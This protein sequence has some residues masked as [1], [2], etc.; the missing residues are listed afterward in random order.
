MNR[1][2]R[3][4]TTKDTKKKYLPQRRKGAKLKKFLSNGQRLAASVI[5]AKACPELCRRAGIQERRGRAAFSRIV[6]LRVLRGDLVF[7]AVLFL[8]PSAVLADEP[9]RA[10]T[11]FS[12]TQAPL[13]AAKEGRYFEKYGIKNLEVIQFSGG[14]PVT[15]ALIGGD[16]QIS[17]TGGAA[18][19]NARLKGADTVII[20]RTVG[21]FPY[22]LYVT[23]DIRDAADLKGKKLAV[24]TVG[25]SGYVAMQYALRKLGIDPDRDVAMLQ[26]G[27][28]GT[29]LASLASGTVQGTLLLPPFTLR[30]RDL[31]LKPLY[32]LVGS[33]IQYPINQITTRQ[34]FIKSQREIVKNF[35]RGFVAGLARFRTDRE[36]G[37]RVLGKNLHETDAKILQETYD[38]WL[39]VFPRVP[40]PG[41]EDATV[42]L[43]FMQVKDQRDWREFVDTSLMDE[44]EREGFTASVY[45]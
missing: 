23:K 4:F 36:F 29:R 1:D 42:F 35:L 39:K 19:V 40:N 16:I 12:A 41:P 18:V 32:D 37:S 27:D 8:L 31:G 44:L 30:A 22:T 34:S 6:F 25:G 33:G 9:L 14:Q 26:V 13:W 28:F 3:F 43:E 24:S 7:A 45:K 2:G 5:S 38:F 15:R 11:I 21:V 20:A 10:G 17:T